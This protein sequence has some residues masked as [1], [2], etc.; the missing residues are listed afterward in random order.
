MDYTMM[1]MTVTMNIIDIIEAIK[2][3]KVFLPKKSIP[4]GW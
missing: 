3:M 2:L 1:I 4:Y